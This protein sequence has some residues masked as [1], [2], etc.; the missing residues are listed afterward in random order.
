MTP[1]SG[2]GTSLS[3]VPRAIGTLS[4]HFHRSLENQVVREG[5][6]DLYIKLTYSVIREDMNKDPAHPG[7]SDDK[8]K[9]PPKWHMSTFRAIGCRRWNKVH[10]RYA[11]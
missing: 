5:E 6:R 10:L 4:C 1:R 8:Q 3:S 9:K 7:D 11:L 2:L